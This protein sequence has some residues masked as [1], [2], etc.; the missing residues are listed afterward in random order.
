VTIDKAMTGRSTYRRF[1][2]ESGSGTES[3]LQYTGMEKHPEAVT[4]THFLCIGRPGSHRYPAGR[5]KPKG[6]FS[7]QGGT[8]VDKTVPGNVLGIDRDGFFYNTIRVPSKTI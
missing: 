8:T 5:E 4:E 3:L 2:R 7:E 1:D 6:G